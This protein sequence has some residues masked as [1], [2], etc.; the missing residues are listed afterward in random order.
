MACA[1]AAGAATV[2]E[3][4]AQAQ[5]PEEK[6]K[7]YKN[8][9]ANVLDV[10]VPAKLEVLLAVLEGSGYTVLAEDEWGL[11]K[12][13]LHPFV[14]PLARKGDFDDDANFEVAGLMMRS[15]TGAKLRPDEY[16][17]VRQC[18]RVSQR[19][20]LMSMEADA[21]IMKRAEE[22]HFRKEV[23][24][25]P[26]I[27]ATKDVY[28]VRFKG[29]DRDALDKW[30]LLE[31]GPFPDV[32]MNL[33]QSHLN[34]EDP[35]TALVIA[36][37]MRDTFGTTWGFAHAFVGQL[38]KDHFKA[39]EEVEDRDME[40]T[41]CIQRCFTTNLPLWTLMDENGSVEDLLSEADVPAITDMEALRWFYTK[42]STDDQRRAVRTFSITESSATLAKAQA[43]MDTSCCGGKTFKELRPQL[44]DLYEEV[45]GTDELVAL[46]DYIAEL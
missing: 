14:I 9:F 26:V 4:T 7:F 12:G 5:V 25:L 45:P 30:L 10:K 13:D 46:F 40:A 38:L 44:R 2:V 19:V 39:Q 41:H 42:R 17:V 3:E 24:D 6:V 33:A 8:F 23:Q 36:D 15:A 34:K 43:L 11:I 28:D 29:S 1:A 27:E 18:P 21:Y 22:A 37:T 35:K 20:A 16:H 32:Y 31:V